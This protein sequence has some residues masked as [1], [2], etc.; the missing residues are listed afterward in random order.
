METLTKQPL[1]D[2]EAPNR[3]TAIVCGASSGLL[4][5]NDIAHPHMYDLYQALLAN[6]WKAQ[7]INMQDAA[8]A[9]V[10]NVGE[11]TGISAD[12]EWVVGINT[13]NDQWEQYPYRYNVATAKFDVMEISEPCPPWDW[14]CWPTPTG[15]SSGGRR[16]SNL[17]R[18]HRRS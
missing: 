18:S 5:W 6:F 10:V 16:R 1:M 12:G 17:S 9:N 14:F 7:E 4:N 3:S 2:P 8:P 13:W 11:A 15:G